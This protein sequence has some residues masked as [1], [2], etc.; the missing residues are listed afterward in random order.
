MS[1]VYSGGKPLAVSGK[2]YPL[3]TGPM[4]YNGP[5]G[6]L[7]EL[8]RGDGATA[9]YD[10]MYRSQ[11]WVYAVVNKIVFGTLRLPLRVWEYGIED[12]SRKKVHAHPLTRLIRNPYPGGSASDI[13]AHVALSLALH[14]H[15]LLLK[16]RNDGVGSAPDE[17]WRIPWRNVQIISDDQGPLGYNI[18]IGAD[19]HW[20][21]PEDVI[22][23][24][25]PGGVSP[26]ASLR[27]TLALEDAAITWQGESLRNGVTPRGAFFT[28]AK[29]NE[30]SFPKLRAE[31]EKL[32]AGPENGGRFGI[33][34][35]G[36][37]WSAM[38]Q[39][40]VDAELLGQRRLSREEVCAALDVPPPL[41]GILENDKGSNTAEMRKSLHDAI[42]SKLVIMEEGFQSQLVDREPSWDGLFVEFDSSELTRPDAETRAR[43]FLMEQQA[44][45]TSVDER[46]AVAGLAPLGL[47]ESQTVFMPLNMQAVGVAPT[48]TDP[49]P[50]GDPAGT[51]EQ[52]QTDPQF[53]TSS[54][55]IQ[56]SLDAAK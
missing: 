20:V 33:F 36:L 31:L 13:K 39:S 30:Q 22:H 19:Q 5:S 45:T 10:F 27:R 35:S 51:P 46:R 12:E 53:L 56:M 26:L 21:G 8:L 6:G 42:A 3:P 11:P 47:P 18:S 2:S 23:H 15:S 38:G 14:G 25:L 28:D 29:L 49:A 4:N 24:E 48:T 40:A 32:Y 43:T 16:S 7:V 41:V 34:D 37:K 54:A 52:G 17:L 44:S 1:V 55:I 9:T 50:E